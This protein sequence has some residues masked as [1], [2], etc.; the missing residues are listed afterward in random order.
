MGTIDERLCQVELASITQILGE[1]AK[2][3]LP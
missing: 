3:S 1:L 2:H